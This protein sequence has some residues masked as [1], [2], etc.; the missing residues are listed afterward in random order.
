[1]ESCLYTH[2]TMLSKV[3]YVADKED[4]NIPGLE[5]VCNLDLVAMVP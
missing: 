1:M 4:I 5:S 2:I 3:C